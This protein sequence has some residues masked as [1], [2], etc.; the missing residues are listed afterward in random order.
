MDDSGQLSVMDHVRAD[1]KV[2]R[3]KQDKEAKRWA[4][5]WRD[6]AKKHKYPNQKRSEHGTT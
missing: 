1:E 5:H 4:K 2:R 3:E 6:L